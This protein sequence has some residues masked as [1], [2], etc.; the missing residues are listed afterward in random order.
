MW[1]FYLALY[2]IGLGIG[3]LR[4][5]VSV[6]V[7]VYI[8]DEVNRSFAYGI[9]AIS[10]IFAILVLFAGTRSYRYKKAWGT[11]QDVQILN[12][13]VIAI[14]K[15]KM[16]LRGNLASLYEDSPEASRIHHTS[17]FRL[18]DKAAIFAHGEFDDEFHSQPLE[19]MQCYEGGGKHD[20]ETRSNVGNN[21]RIL[22]QLCT[23]G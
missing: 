18:L 11:L 16:A 12:V 2:T 9:S 13:T 14:R 1:I 3:G 21:H 4:S 23:D 15:R 6:S 7:L 10:M 5:S 22:D 8:Q 19:A 20:D 17:Q